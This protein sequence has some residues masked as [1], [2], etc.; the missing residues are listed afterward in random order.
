M[1]RVIRLMACVALAACGGEDEKKPTE[2][3]D[4][5][6]APPAQGFQLTTGAFEVPVG[7]EIQDCHFFAVPENELSPGEPLW[8]NRFTI[9]QNGGTHH[10]NVFRVNTVHDLGGKHGDVVRGDEARS[11]PCWKSANWADWPL[12]VNS[13]ASTGDGTVDWTLPEGVAQKFMPG[14]LLMLQTHYVNASTQ[15]T[16]LGHGKVF[17][18]FE[19]VEPSKVEHEMGTLFATNQNIQICPGDQKQFSKTCNF[20]KDEPLHIIAANGHFH[21]RGIRFEGFVYDPTT[22][23]RGQMFYESETWDD[24]P[25]ARDFNFVVPAKGGIEYTCEFRAEADDCGDPTKECCYTFGGSVDEQEHCN[26]FLYY[27]PK[28]VDF[29]CF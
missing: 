3:T 16:D 9:R 14:E 24:P 5:E 25:M 13:Q 28:Q 20:A 6:L 27:Y 11:N 29:G 10:M 23:E 21:S 26:L 12:V 7:R 22:D 8:I 2:A 15:Q 19:Q 17:V 1:K 18:N 4:V